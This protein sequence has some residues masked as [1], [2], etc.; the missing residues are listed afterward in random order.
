[1]IMTTVVVVLATVL[2]V[3]RRRATVATVVLMVKFI[4]AMV[5]HTQVNAISHLPLILYC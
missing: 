5:R 2:V 1:M 3:I 4:P